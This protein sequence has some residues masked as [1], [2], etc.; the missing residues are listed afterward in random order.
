MKKDLAGVFTDLKDNLEQALKGTES[1]VD[2]VAGRM[3]DAS[4]GIDLKTEHPGD[5]LIKKLQRPVHKI[6]KEAVN[7][8]KDLR[9]V[10]K[11][12]I[13]GVFRVSRKIREEAH[14]TIGLITAI[15][16][17]AISKGGGDL[18]SAT[19]GIINGFADVAKE[20][21]LNKGEAIAKASVCAL[22]TAHKIDPDSSRKVKKV[23]NEKISGARQIFK[24]ATFKKVSSGNKRTAG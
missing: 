4:R 24:K 20:Q 12:I 7:Q 21:D 1:L 2:Q 14:Q 16:I 17:K 5:E 23:I 22:E 3:V 13:I 11:G 9:V 10:T 18:K 6:I 19:R 8:K 15:I